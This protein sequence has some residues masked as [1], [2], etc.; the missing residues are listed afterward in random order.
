MDSPTST[1]E[2]MTLRQLAVAVQPEWP[3][4]PRVRRVYLMLWK[5]ATRGSRG[6]RLEAERVSGR[7]WVTLDAWEKFKRDCT[8]KA[9]TPHER[10]LDDVE[11]ER[12]RRVRLEKLRRKARQ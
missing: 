7:W 4:K 8:A 9:L 5:Y 3:G 11:T 2:N 12:Q 10:I 6:I 1:S